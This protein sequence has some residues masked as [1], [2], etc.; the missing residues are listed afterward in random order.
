MWLLGADESKVLTCGSQSPHWCGY[1]L[2]ISFKH[3]LVMYLLKNVF[4]IFFFF[5][6]FEN[7]WSSDFLLVQFSEEKTHAITII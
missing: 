7:L 6:V 1:S 3:W 2:E 4:K 5:E